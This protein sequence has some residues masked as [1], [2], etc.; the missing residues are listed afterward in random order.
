MNHPCIYEE[1]KSNLKSKW[2]QPAVTLAATLVVGIKLGV[3]DPQEEALPLGRF[4]AVE[5]LL[6]LLC[7]PHSAGSW[8]ALGQKSY[9]HDGQGLGWGLELVKG[10]KASPWI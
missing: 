6:G 3:S 7:G 1:E 10:T 9:N 4:A 2:W 8:R 5:G